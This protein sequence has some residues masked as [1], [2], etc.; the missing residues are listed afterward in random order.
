MQTTSAKHADASQAIPMPHANR[1]DDGAGKIGHNSGDR[2]AALRQ[3]ITDYFTE[4]RK[5]AAISTKAMPAGERLALLRNANL[6]AQIRYVRRYPNADAAPA[7]LTLIYALADNDKQQ[8]TASLSRMAEVLGRHRVRVTKAYGRLKKAGL[9]HDGGTKT[10]TIANPVITVNARPLDVLDTLAPRETSN[11][12]VTSAS[13]TSITSD[14]EASNASVTSGSEHLQRSRASLVTEPCAACNV[15]RYTTFP[16]HSPTSPSQARTTADAVG[17]N[18]PT[19][20]PPGGK[21]E[22]ADEKT[23]EAG[24]AHAAGQSPLPIK[25][26]PRASEPPRARAGEP[27][28]ATPDAARKTTPVG[29]AFAAYNERAA[30]H[31]WVSA[32][33]LD[34]KLAQSIGARLKDYQPAGWQRA[35]GNAERSRFLMGQVPGTDGRQPFKLNIG[36]LAHPDNFRKVHDGFYGSDARVT[37]PAG[38]PLNGKPGAPGRLPGESDTDYL[39]RAQREAAAV[40][41]AMQ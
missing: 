23:A 33:V 10:S 4:Q 28:A 7:L 35:L 18:A 6:M 36:W 19:P 17:A 14:D 40:R 34:K 13:N 9:V 15:P 1:S 20:I 3:A 41:R 38:K 21:A 27:P 8:C 30:R 11:T 16:S 22:F 29:E 2:T 12:S 31:G 32:S 26:E 5:A 37:P 25:P 24:V 39:L